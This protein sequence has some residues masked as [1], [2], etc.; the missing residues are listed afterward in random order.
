MSAPESWME[1]LSDFYSSVLVFVVVSFTWHFFCCC[2]LHLQMSKDFVQLDGHAWERAACHALHANLT[3]ALSLLFSNLYFQE[4][5]QVGVWGCSEG[6]WG[7]IRAQMNLARPKKQRF[8]FEQLRGL[9][10]IGLHMM[11]APDSG[12]SWGWDRGRRK[13]HGRC[14]QVCLWLVNRFLI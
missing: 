4:V 13:D 12:G 3:S 6:H 8:N 14:T 9:F 5:C 1:G 11:L 2:V 7:I 10:T